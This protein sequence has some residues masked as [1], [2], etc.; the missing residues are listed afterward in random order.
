M[1]EYAIGEDNPN[2]LRSRNGSLGWLWVVFCFFPSRTGSVRSKSTPVS[3]DG[4]YFPKLLGA[5]KVD[6]SFWEIRKLAR[7]DVLELYRTPVAQLFRPWS[8]FCVRK[9]R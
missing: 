7:P 5:R 4:N 1:I 6:S 8:N 9:L 2:F 3:G